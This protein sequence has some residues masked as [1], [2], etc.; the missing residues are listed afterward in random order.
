M[1]GKSESN[2]D[3]VFGNTNPETFAKQFIAF[4]AKLKQ[5]YSMLTLKFRAGSL[6]GCLTLRPKPQYL[7]QNCG[8]V[9]G[10]CKTILTV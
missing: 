4:T 7:D 8:C 2:R 1:P 10:H 6:K 9:T 5:E 3:K